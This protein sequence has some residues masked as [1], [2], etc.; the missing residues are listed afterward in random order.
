[1]DH[2]PLNTNTV[3]QNGINEVIKALV[4]T[5]KNTHEHTYQLSKYRMPNESIIDF[6]TRTHK[7]IAQ[8][9]RFESMI[10]QNKLTL[11]KNPD[12]TKKLNADHISLYNKLTTRKTHKIAKRKSKT[13]ID[14]FSN[15][16]AQDKVQ[17]IELECL[18][19]VLGNVQKI[20]FSTDGIFSPDT[21]PLEMIKIINSNFPTITRH[22]IVESLNDSLKNKIHIYSC[23]LKYI[24]RDEDTIL[25]FLIYS[26]FSIC[27]NGSAKNDV[28]FVHFLMTNPYFPKSKIGSLLLSNLI[29]SFGNCDFVLEAGTHLVSYYQKFLFHKRKPTYYGYLNGFYKFNMNNNTTFLVRN[30]TKLYGI[31]NYNIFRHEIHNTHDLFQQIN[32]RRF[33]RKVDHPQVTIL[34]N[35]LWTHFKIR[36]SQLGELISNTIYQF[37][38][39]MGSHDVNLLLEQE[40]CWDKVWSVI[41]KLCLIGHTFIYCNEAN[42][43]YVRIK[44]HFNSPLWKKIIQSDMKT[45]HEEINMLTV[46]NVLSLMFEFIQLLP[47]LFK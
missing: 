7:K 27:Q 33:K 11:G 8:I 24:D 37:C 9:K 42:I 35:S 32:F 29:E 15:D 26:K 18:E 5:E 19:N 43:K 45:N 4:P 20:Y 21:I 12:L 14:T 6:L 40:K 3:E 10:K 13:G 46:Y 31:E 34:L 17:K 2:K 36:K 23:N 22:N 39:A 25:S 38:E 1:M 44:Q 41:E 47:D 30:S 28:I 16:K